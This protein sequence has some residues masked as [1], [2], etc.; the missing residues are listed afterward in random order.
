MHIYKLT[1]IYDACGEMVFRRGGR[2]A[3]TNSYY[4]YFIYGW[5]RGQ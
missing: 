4:Y 3:G 2:A 5:Y 1:C